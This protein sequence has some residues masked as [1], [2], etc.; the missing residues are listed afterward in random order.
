VHLSGL[1]F[2]NKAETRLKRENMAPRG[3]N[4]LHHGR[5]TKNIAIKNNTR[6]VSLSTLGH[7]TGWPEA[8]WEI[9]V[10]TADS[11]APAG[12]IRHMERGCSSPKKY[13]TNKT[14]PIKIT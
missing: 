12:Q 13:G 9:I 5:F 14:V 10:G 6:I 8:A 2:K 3:H 7:T 4:I 11:I 1:N